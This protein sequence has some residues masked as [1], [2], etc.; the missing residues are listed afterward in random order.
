MKQW[1]TRFTFMWLASV[2]E[3]CPVELDKVSE[4]NNT[5]EHKYVPKNVWSNSL[6]FCLM[7]IKC[8]N[9]CL[10]I[11]FPNNQMQIDLVVKTFDG[12]S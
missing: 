1:T 8:Q 5:K 4:L 2:L 7:R 10:V 3:T 12:V 6:F 9:V 11:H